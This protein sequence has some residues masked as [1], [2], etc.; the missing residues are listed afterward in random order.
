MAD[1]RA[2]CAPR[3]T[4]VL[5]VLV[6][7]CEPAAQAAMEHDDPRWLTPSPVPRVALVVGAQYYKHPDRLPEARNALNDARAIANVLADAGFSVSLSE[8]PKRDKLLA[9]IRNFADK[10]EAIDGPV[11][12]AFFFAGHGFHSRGYNYIVPVDAEPRDLMLT[13]LPVPHL[14]EKLARRKAGIAVLFLD[15][16]RSELAEEGARGP[17]SVSRG[18]HQPDTPERAFVGFAT[19][20]GDLA[21]GFAKD[22]DKN[23]PFTTA[24]ALL[25][26]NRGVPIEKLFKKVRGAVEQATKP[27]IQSPRELN[28]LVGE[29]Y[30]HP[31][32]HQREEERSLWLSALGSGE[33]EVVEAYLQDYPDSAYAHAARLWLMSQGSEMGDP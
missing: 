28:S 31:T 2:R 18:F 3:I 8:D 32:D 20:F 15:A 23:S 10:L 27:E 22:G 11:I 17:G 19:N 9:D 16:C 25:V 33:V 6:C 7:V 24:L 29:F 14:L 21:K 5:S 30:F 4:L 12:A 26:P 1:Y 13:S